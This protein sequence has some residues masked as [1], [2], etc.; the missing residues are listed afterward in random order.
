MSPAHPARI[1]LS[2]LARALAE[3]GP[4]RAPMA[5]LAR[6]AGVAKPTL[7]ARFGSREGLVRACVEHEAELL[8]DHVYGPGEPGAAI[9]S[10]AQESPGWSLLL[11]SRH[12][13]VV[14]ARRRIA[15]RIAEGRRA[16]GDLRPE[17]AAPAFLAA[18]AAIL[19]TEAPA[20]AAKSLRHVAAALL[21]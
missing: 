14:A 20:A 6:A 8:L 12:D 11:L 19:E 16:G 2:E 17:A 4:E 18:A 10:Y 21:P 5:D 7:F 15:A 1:E 13:A 9:G 3:L